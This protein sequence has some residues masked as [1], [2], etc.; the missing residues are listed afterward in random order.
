M[1]AFFNG[2]EPQQTIIAAAAAVH[3]LE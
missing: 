1:R 2:I 3:D